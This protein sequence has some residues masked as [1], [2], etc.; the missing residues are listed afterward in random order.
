MLFPALL[1]IAWGTVT[2]GSPPPLFPQK[3]VHLQIPTRDF[4][5]QPYR[6]KFKIPL[7]FRDFQK[8]I[9]GSP[10]RSRHP[11]KA[12]DFR[13]IFEGVRSPVSPGGGNVE[14]K[15]FTGGKAMHSPSLPR[16]KDI[17]ESTNMN[18]PP[19]RNGEDGN[20]MTHLSHSRSHRDLPIKLTEN[21]V[22]NGTL[23]YDHDHPHYAA[24]A[25]EKTGFTIN[26]TADHS[27]KKN[28]EESLPNKENGKERLWHG[29]KRNDF[30]MSSFFNITPSDD[31]IFVPDKEFERNKSNV[32]EDMKDFLKEKELLSVKN[33]NTDEKDKRVKL[34]SENLNEER[35]FTNET[36]Y[37]TAETLSNIAFNSE[38]NITNITVNSKQIAPKQSNI[39]NGTDAYKIS[40]NV[41][42]QKQTDRTPK[43]HASHFDSSLPRLNQSQSKNSTSTSHFPMQQDEAYEI[44]TAPSSI[45]QDN[46][47]SYN[48]KFLNEGSRS[49][50][51]DRFLENASPNAVSLTVTTADSHMNDPPFRGPNVPPEIDSFPKE[52]D[53]SK[54]DYHGRS[55]IVESP[56]F[57]S[58]N[59]GK[60]WKQARELWGIAWDCH[61]Y[62]MGALFA[63]IS[64]YSFISLLRIKTFVTLLST[65]ALRKQGEMIRLTF[66][67]MHIDGAQLP[68]KLPK[69]TLGLAVKL[70][71]VS[72]FI[73]LLLFFLSPYAMVFLRGLFP[74]ME[75]PNPWFWWG[76]QLTCRILELVMCATM[77]FV[78]TQPLKHF[79]IN[80]SRFCS[81]LMWFPCSSFAECFRKEEVVDFEAHSDNYANPQGLRSTGFNIVANSRRLQTN[82]LPTFRT[83]L[84]EV[85]NNLPMRTLPC[86]GRHTN[87]ASA[88]SL[89][90]YYRR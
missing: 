72:S 28:F 20:K 25:E 37:Q 16:G 82:S 46:S 26:D 40:T 22:E 57:Q 88:L 35:T 68:K 83:P 8:S 33:I 52:K 34:P 27:H 48:S 69:P 9:A 56:S 63:I 43:L 19:H 59:S 78:A 85:D 4:S 2:I 50:N 84:T 54:S 47:E 5:S 86:T 31:K 29:E 60:E 51:D 62:I 12:V 79:E 55:S 44:I 7:I 23:V 10:S 30:K 74:G 41:P 58:S 66:T 32:Y 14:G 81:I 36:N 39:F 61:C 70:V 89:L 80:D 42:S 49:N 53:E 6:E 77:S 73:Q 24:T 67:K 17:P 64:I 38:K 13:K 76:Y 90:S 11:A 18:I 75:V 71:L 15:A 45:F 65:G 21:G 1:L 3:E 87:H